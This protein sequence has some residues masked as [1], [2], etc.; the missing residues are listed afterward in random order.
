GLG[1]MACAEFAKV[2]YAGPAIAFS[3]GIA[4][5]ASLTLTPALLKLLGKRVFWPTKPPA[6]LTMLRL[7]QPT[8]LGLWDWV[9]HWVVR[10]PGRIWFAAAALLVPLV[11]VGLNVHPDYRATGELSPQT[12]SLAGLSAIQRHFTTG[13]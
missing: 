3:L 4:L 10:R 6:P 11:L 12:Q 1:M 2:R 9:S 5:C 8:K 13:E 7:A